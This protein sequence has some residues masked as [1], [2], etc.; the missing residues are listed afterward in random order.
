M[1][2]PPQTGKRILIVDDDFTT[3]E[4]M[5]MILAGEGYRAAVARN[6]AEALE[7]LRDFERPEVI[8]LDLRMPVMDGCDFCKHRQE[9]PELSSIPV[10]VIS[11]LPD[12]A[13]QAAALG[14]VACLCK[15]IDTIALLGKLRECCVGAACATG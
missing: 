7:R 10:V 14:A 5:S 11:G 15:P 12:A 1:A 4:C 9:N 6:G 13:Q 3:G 8:L 2:A